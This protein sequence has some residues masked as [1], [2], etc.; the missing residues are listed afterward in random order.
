M[1]ELA[2]IR[3]N[4]FVRCHQCTFIM[5]KIPKDYSFVFKYLKF[6]RKLRYNT[7]LCLTACQCQR[8]KI[9]NTIH[10]KSII[11]CKL[12]NRIVCQRFRTILS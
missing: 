11:E 9:C 8:N 10:F 6:T 4:D 12:I 2:I 1:F 5:I 7:L 3:L